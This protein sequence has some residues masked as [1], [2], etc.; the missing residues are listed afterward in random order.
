MMRTLLPLALVAALATMTPLALAQDAEK[1]DAPQ[2]GGEA[3]T[4]DC[5]PDMM[6]AYS[7]G[8]REAVDC[9]DPANASYEACAVCEDCP[10]SH[11]DAGDQPTNAGDCGADVCALDGG[12]QGRCMDGSAECDWS[13]CPNCRTL[14]G[15][16]N[17]EDLADDSGPADPVRAESD[18]TKVQNE[19]PGVALVGTLAVLAGAAIVLRRRG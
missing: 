4:K 19:V 7:G 5:P 11:A 9:T 14:D 2:D 6:C 16:E 17:A 8:E 15:S 13:D 12:P 1:T 3:W 10:K 18:D